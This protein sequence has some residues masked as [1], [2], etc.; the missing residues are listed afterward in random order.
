M[1]WVKL[2]TRYYLDPAVA[3]LP[4]ADTELLF[5]RG[6]AY[7]GAEETGGFIP[8]VIVASLIRRRRYGAA[9]EALVARSLWIPCTGDRGQPGYR[10]SRWGDWQEELDSLARRR[11]NDRERKRRQRQAGREPAQEEE[12]SRDMS[13]DSPVTCP[14]PKEREVEVD[15]DPPPLAPSSRVPPEGRKRPATATRLPPGFTVTPDMVA[16]AREH[17]PKVDGR[18][19]TEMFRDHWNSASGARARKVDWTAAWRNWMRKAD[20]DIGR[21]QNG[22]SRQSRTQEIAGLFDDNYRIAEQIEEM[23]ARRNDANGNG[24]AGGVRPRALPAP[25]D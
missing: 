9:V 3:S 6:L 24:A 5:V 4:D 16:W 23:E 22:G 17:V 2:G 21:Q 25:G 12:M 11:A 18:R 1:D 20:D 7:A 14:P 13:A 19:Q 8:E 10:I 15:K